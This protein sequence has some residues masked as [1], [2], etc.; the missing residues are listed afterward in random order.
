MKYIPASGENNKT[1]KLT[2]KVFGI[3]LLFAGLFCLADAF[4]QRFFFT[5]NLRV[6]MFEPPSTFRDALFGNISIHSKFIR[7]GFLAACIIGGW[8]AFLYLK[9]QLFTENRYRNYIQGAPLGIMIFDDDGR[10]IRVNHEAG[11][12]TGYSE[13][14]LLKLQ[15]NVLNPLQILEGKSIPFTISRNLLP[16]SSEIIIKTKSG[17]NINIQVDGVQLTDESTLLFFKDITEQKLSQEILKNNLR[18]KEILLGEVHHR[19]K[20]NLSIIISLL[21][22]QDTE[23]CTNESLTDILAIVQNRIFAIAMVHEKLYQSESF[24]HIDFND[25]LKS[26]ASYLF[27]IYKK[28][29]R[30][31]LEFDLDQIEM[32]IKTAVPC[33]IICSELVTNAFK[34]AFKGRDKGKVTILLKKLNENSCALTI[35]DDG[36]GL[37]ETINIDELSSLGL[38]L[39]SILT[40]QIDGNIKVTTENGTAFS[41]TFPLKN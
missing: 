31:G 13:K 34:H 27:Q 40:S 38:K 19:V 15:F 4:F 11:V 8:I 30:I 41:V 16:I 23:S 24:T 36:V 35:K 39:V 12:L 9:Q 10:L 22:L 21:S 17:K 26:L 20:N 29:P 28:E 14:E 6:M 7:L 2:V 5:Q 33:G 18:E 1:L 3:A 32:N 37:T 25:Y